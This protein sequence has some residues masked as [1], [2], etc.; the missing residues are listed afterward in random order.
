MLQLLIFAQVFFMFCEYKNTATLQLFVI[1]IS[2]KTEKL[3]PLITRSG[4]ILLENEECPD[5]LPSEEI[6]NVIQ[7][8]HKAQVRNSI[9][10]LFCS[11]MHISSYF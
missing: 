7:C 6:K 10:K 4:N 5:H 3:V 8:Y 11:D 1:G 2:T 9:F